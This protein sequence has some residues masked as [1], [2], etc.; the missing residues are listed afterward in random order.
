MAEI[1]RAEDFARM[2]AHRKMKTD[3]DDRPL[4]NICSLE[5]GEKRGQKILLLRR[6]NRR[7]RRIGIKNSKKVNFIKCCREAEREGD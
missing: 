2:R 5:G 6:R 3:W 7:I 1:K 4:G